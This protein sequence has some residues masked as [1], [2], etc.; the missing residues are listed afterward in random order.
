MIYEIKLSIFAITSII[1]AV[2]LNKGLFLNSA[3][4]KVI[5]FWIIVIPFVFIVRNEMVT[6]LV[7]ALSLPGISYLIHLRYWKVAVIVIL[8]PL[9]FRLNSINALKWNATDSFIVL[10]VLYISFMVSK[11]LSILVSFRYFVDQLLIYIVP[12]FVISRFVIT[13]NDAHSC[14]F[15]FLLLAILLAAVMVMSQLVQ[16]DI[17]N[18][19]E[20]VFFGFP[21]LLMVF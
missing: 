3:G 21:G 17:Y 5:A 18:A 1:S 4:K 9:L 19:I 10:F 20:A 11:E 15:G 6:V 12:Y 8:I 7:C 13:D 14:A 2:L 16:T